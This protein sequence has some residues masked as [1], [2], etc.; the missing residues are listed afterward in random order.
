MEEQKYT[1]V[2]IDDEKDSQQMLIHLLKGFPE[3]DILETAEN[4]IDGEY[5]ITK[6]KPD[7]A[8]VDID[9]PGKNGVE[10]LK[11]LHNLNLKTR[12]I[13]TTAHESYAVESISY[14]PFGYLLKPVSKEEVKKVLCHV[15]KDEQKDAKSHDNANHKL[16]ISS[17]KEIHFINYDEIAF[18]T[19]E[20]NYTRI[21]LTNKEQVNVSLQIS[22]VLEQLPTDHFFRINRSEVVNLKYVS[23]LKRKNK[24]LHISTKMYPVNIKVASN[25]IHEL[26]GRL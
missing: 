10:I 9:M 22:K 25:K 15:K 5:I 18:L 20:G 2:V 19:A 16:R 21:T 17:K 6:H 13:F 12:V 1:A 26:E 7:L 3:I 4:G 8:F 14:H 23:R 24:K 11:E